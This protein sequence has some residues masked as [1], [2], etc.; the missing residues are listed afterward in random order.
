MDPKSNTMVIEEYRL[1]QAGI[2]VI[3]ALIIRKDEPD[4][5]LAPH[6]QENRFYGVN[7]RPFLFWAEI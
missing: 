5:P 7:P 6:P 3:L 4:R 1:L 2:V